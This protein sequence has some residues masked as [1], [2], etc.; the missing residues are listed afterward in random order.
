MS[1][2]L[3]AIPFFLA[4][5]LLEIIVSKRLNKPVYRFHDAVTSINIGFISE[6][7]R[8]IAKLM[9]IA[10]YAVVVEHVASFTWDIKNPAVW[11]LAFFMY[12]FFYY[13][14]HRSGHEVNLLWASHVVHHSSEEFNLSTAFRQSWTNQI[15]Y[16]I[17]YLPMAIAGIPVQVFVITALASAIYQFW[18]HTRLVSK[19]GWFER[20]FVTPSHH[21]VHHGRNAYCIDK[22]Y[23]GTLIIWDRMFKTF[24]EERDAE[25]VVYGTLKP[26]G[27]WNPVWANFKNFIGVFGLAWS[28]AGWRNKLMVVFAPPGW[29]PQGQALE[30]TADMQRTSLATTAST[31]QKVYGVLSVI[32]IL[33]LVLDLLL[34]SQSMGMPARLVLTVL[35]AA[36][37]ASLAWLFEGK[38]GAL[39]LET[40]RTLGIFVPLVLGVWFHAVGPLAQAGGAAALVVFLGLLAMLYRERATAPALQMKAAA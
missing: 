28:T 27:S 5:I 14:A 18:V 22:N 1:L 30:D 7:F 36:N 9:S 29:M 34:A 39:E 8:S 37:T 12:D 23:G 38:R 21:R 4:L 19:L 26:I 25:P 10:V 16:W 3:F 2:I 31:L 20:V 11:V 6:L 40:L 13:W 35:I 32:A 17:F 24:A 33:G 15:F